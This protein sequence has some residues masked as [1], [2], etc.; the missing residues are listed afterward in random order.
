MIAFTKFGNYGRFGNQLFQYAY[1]RSQAKRLSTKFYCP[2]WRGDEVF[3]LSDAEEK[4]PPFTPKHMYHEDPYKHGFQESA[5][6]MR[7]DT[8]VAGFFQ[9]PL[10]FKKEDVL[11]WFSFNESL[12][13]SVRAKYGNINLN[14]ATAIHL[15]LGDYCNPSSLMFYTIRPEYVKRALSLIKEGGPILVISDSPETAKKYLG[16]M[17]EG[18]IFVEGNKD[19]EDFYLLAHAKNIICSASSFSWWAAYL[20]KH[21]NKKVFMPQYWFL[22]M[23]RVKNETI[24]LDVWTRLPAHRP[25]LDN[26]YVRYALFN[27]G[28][29]RLLPFLVKNS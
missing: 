8:D 3:M 17:P 19:Y 25:L 27:L 4:C 16:H 23:S 13:A 22:P 6:Q 10:F 7:D 18:T 24:F 29:G 28:F 5:T 14:K 20:N 12:F 26:Y 2:P 21:P 1:L 11:R 9:S 15:R